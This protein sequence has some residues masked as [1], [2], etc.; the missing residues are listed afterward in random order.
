MSGIVWGLLSPDQ[1]IE[2]QKALLTDATGIDTSVQ[3]CANLD[4]GTKASWTAFYAAVQAFCAE[5]PVWLFPWAAGEVLTTRGLAF[6]WENLTRELYAWK[7]LLSTRCTMTVPTNFDPL[8]SPADPASA[9]IESTVKY[10]AVAAVF[11]ASAMVLGKA[12]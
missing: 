9:A 1:V 7:Q 8:A 11:L 2:G 10:V 5:K 3:N 12:I 6:E 4:A